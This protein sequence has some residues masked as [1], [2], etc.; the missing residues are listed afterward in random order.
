MKTTMM[1]LCASAIVF[2]GCASSQKSETSAIPVN[3]V[4]PMMIEHPVPAEH[5]TTVSYKGQTVGFCCADCVGEWERM[6]D[7]AKDKALKNAIAASK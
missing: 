6:S 5:A 7:T 1:L 2:A 3:S 4:C